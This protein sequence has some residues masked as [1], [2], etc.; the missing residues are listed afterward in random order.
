MSVFGPA[1]A[2]SLPYFTA[3]L[4]QYFYNSETRDERK[5]RTSHSES[6]S[7]NALKKIFLERY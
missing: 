4:I 7:T 2:R 6:A 5:K 3:S 1:L